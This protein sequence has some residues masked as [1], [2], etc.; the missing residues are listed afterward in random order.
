M[1]SSKSTQHFWSQL[2]LS[3]IAIFALPQAQGL[4]NANFADENYVKQSRQLAIQQ[5]QQQSQQKQQIQSQFVLNNRQIPATK[6][7]L[8]NIPHFLSTLNAHAIIIRA[9]PFA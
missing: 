5:S 8:K 4:N 3:M 1:I 7:R 9:G 2:I 6:I